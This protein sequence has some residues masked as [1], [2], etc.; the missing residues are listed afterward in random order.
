MNLHKQQS[1]EKPHVPK[2]YGRPDLLSCLPAAVNSES[3]VFFPALSSS[4]LEIFSSVFIFLFQ[5]QLPKNPKS[6]FCRSLLLRLDF[7]Q[8]YLFKSSVFD[9]SARPGLELGSNNALLCLSF[10]TGELKDHL[11]SFVEETN[12]QHRPG[13]I[14]V[15]RHDK[16][17][18]LIR[19]RVSG[20][21]AASAPVV[22]LF[23]AHVEFSTGW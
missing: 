23:D 18:G 22:A 11:Q 2:V 4:G 5:L 17:E 6:I 21:R 15:V 19:S 20:W 12:A 3:G 9:H 14:K 10:S 7:T 1:A 13:F 8:L 16:Q